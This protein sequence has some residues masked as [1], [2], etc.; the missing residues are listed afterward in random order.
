LKREGGR[1]P[2][3]LFKKACKIFT[4]FLFCKLKKTTIIKS[5]ETL[6]LISRI[7]TLYLK[8][9]PKDFESLE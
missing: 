9:R 2:D 5:E 4:S 3:G 8:Y 1:R 7:M 6:V